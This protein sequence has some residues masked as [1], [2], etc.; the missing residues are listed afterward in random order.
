MMLIAPPGGQICNFMLA[1]PSGQSCN[2]VSIQV[3]NFHYRLGQ[4]NTVPSLPTVQNTEP[5]EHNLSNKFFGS[6][7]PLPQGALQVKY[8]S[9][10]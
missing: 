1:A 8:C 2:L 6:P 5:I 7:C 3:L 10:S 4:L 9:M